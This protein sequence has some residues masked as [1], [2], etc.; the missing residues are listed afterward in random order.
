ML[1][2]IFISYR[3]DDSAGTTGRLYD[4]ITQAFP[5]EKVFMDVD[6]AMHGLD[7]V[8]VLDEKIAASSLVAVVIGPNWLTATNASGQR[9]I[10]NQDDFVR[11]ELRAALEREIPVIPVLVDGAAMPAAADLPAD[12]RALSRRHAIE[13]RNTRFG[14]DANSLVDALERRLGTVKRRR[15]FFH[16]A[17]LVLGALVA[18]VIGGLA[19]GWP[20]ADVVPGLR[21]ASTKATDGASGKLAAMADNMSNDSTG[22]KS[23]APSVAPVE[24]ESDR[25]ERELRERIVR[26]ETDA[27]VRADDDRTREDARKRQDELIRAEEAEQRQSQAAALAKA[28][29]AA[30]EARKAKE[31]LEAEHNRQAK[32]RERQTRELNE[33]IARIEAD[34]RSRA[35][36]V[37]PGDVCEK[38]WHQR[39]AI[40]RRFSYCFT[41]DKAISVFG[42]DGCFRNQG[43]A[44]QAMGETNR[45]A[46]NRIK[47]QER[48]NGC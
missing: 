20:V 45:G 6:A 19:A 48:A 16:A 22:F 2:E 10:D 25:R 3:R 31:E 26:L 1:G 24:S 36:A 13:V 14:D 37:A 9:R 4:R 39:N 27:R 18:A 23:Q 41:T 21:F 35:Q 7:F 43:D 5:R 12:I 30:D 8:R 17:A 29:S 33:R 44:W 38:L 46:V 40:Y 11:I 28:K 32:E 34:G 42:N 15:W 47:E